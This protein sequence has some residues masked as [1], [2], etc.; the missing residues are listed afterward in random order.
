MPKPSGTPLPRAPHLSRLALISIVLSAGAWAQSSPHPTLQSTTTLVFVPALVKTPGKD[1]VYSLHASDFELTDNGVAQ[2]VTLEEDWAQPLSLVVVVQ[3]GGAARRQFANFAHLDTMLAG[4]LGDPP[5]GSPQGGDQSPQTPNRTPQ[6]QVAIVD[7]DSQPEYDSPFTADVT[8][9]AAEL[10]HPHHG[11]DEAAI[12]DALAYALN[13]L[14]QP[15]ETRHAILLISQQHDDG[16][17]TRVEDIVRELG[18]SNTAVYALTFSAEKATLK[19]DFTDPAHLTGPLGPGWGDLTGFIQYF[20]L[21]APLRLAAG[22]LRSNVA[23]GVAS[24]S[25]GEPFDFSNKAGFDRALNTLANH[26]HNGYTLSFHPT[27][28]QPGLH[29]LKL[30][31]VNHPDFLVDARANY[32]ADPAAPSQ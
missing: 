27:S 21:A 9:W 24:L 2:K 30:R 18:E 19:Q 17:T 29:T 12:F 20:D 4:I 14:R 10:D 7:F 16:S 28:N 15:P 32:W 26:I 25:G 5:G 31:V 1:L 8:Q 11:D 22:A 6:N 13:M 3:I 23:A